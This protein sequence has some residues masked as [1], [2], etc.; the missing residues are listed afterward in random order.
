MSSNV[1]VILRLLPLLLIYIVLIILTPRSDFFGDEGGYVRFATNLTHGYYS[2]HS[3]IDLW[4]GPGYPII[5]APFVLFKAPWLIVKLLNAFFLFAAV[6]YFHQTIRLYTPT[7]Y[8]LSLSYLFGLYL[9]FLRFLSYIFT[10][11]L[12]ALLVSAIT[13]HFCKVNR[14]TRNGR[15]HLLFAGIS[16]G[17][18]AL[19][20]V[21][22]GYAIVASLII[23]ALAFMFL[24][25]HQIIKRAI[26]VCCIAFVVCLPYLVY[27]YSL[28][29]K[30][31]YWG[32]SGGMQLYWMSTPFSDELGDWQFIEQIKTNPQLAANHLAFYEK[33]AN[34]S[35]VDRDDAFKREAIRN[36]VNHPS[37]Y[38]RNWLNNIGR[39]FFDYPY[40]YVNQTPHTYF[41][42]LPD[43]FIIVLG[44]LSIY[45]AWRWRG[46]IPNEILVLVVFAIVAIGGSSLVS[47]YARQFWVL[48]PIIDLFIISV[49]VNTV[50]LRLPANGVDKLCEPVPETKPA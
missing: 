7:R 2:P 3:E 48:T 35:S 32:N 5:L 44:I 9:P 46:N 18:L 40:S 17:Y 28:T 14:L 30:P 36:I 20:K 27:T 6:I 49:L 19:T 21:V 31:F 12:A 45:P 4:W 29:G 22:F 42:M 16:L 26:F 8:V 11:T 50:A 33:V 1:K 41:Y 13:Y 23:C 38:F 47:A 15:P 43:M 34:L 25:K 39:L 10:E 24:K 37:K